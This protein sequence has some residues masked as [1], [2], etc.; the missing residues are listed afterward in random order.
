MM[1]T[2]MTG[3][4][5][6]ATMP[7]TPTMMLTPERMTPTRTCLNDAV[8]V[9]II[10]VIN[11]DNNDDGVPLSM[12]PEAAAAVVDIVVLVTN[13]LD[14]HRHRRGGQTTQLP[15]GGGGMYYTYR[16]MGDGWRGA[17]LCLATT[18]PHR[19]RDGNDGR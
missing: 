10:V 16:R 4:Q 1:T 7:T 14:G 3:R 18:V 19:L 8:I 13:I 15:G 6:D 5:E 17:R 11:Y 2:T 9:F 12:L